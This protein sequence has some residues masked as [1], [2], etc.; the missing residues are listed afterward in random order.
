MSQHEFL[1]NLPGDY[2]NDTYYILTH[3]TN[4]S[5]Q[6]S[7]ANNTTLDIDMSSR[8]LVVCIHGIG[9]FHGHFDY[10]VPVLKQEGYQI[11]VYDLLCRGYS[12]FPKTVVR[13]DG[14]SIFD[15]M[16]HVDQL[17]ELL[18]GLK[19][20][21]QKYH[22]VG[23]SMG[24]ALATLYAAQYPDEIASVT[25]LSPA[26]LMDLG[27]VKFL[28]KCRCLHGIVRSLL[29]NNQETAWRDDFQ[30]QTKPIVEEA[31]NKIRQVYSPKHFEGFWSSVLSFPLFD[32]QET[33]ATLGSSHQIPIFLA[34]AQHDRAVPF[35]PS[36]DRWQQ[37][38]TES[39]HPRVKYVVYEDGAHGFFIEF[40]ELVNKDILKFIKS[41]T[42]SSSSFEEKV[43][44]K[45]RERER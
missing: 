37:I 25:L 41:T 14:T 5:A 34:W 12:N 33:V 10:L 26:G 15:G 31:L 6:N 11:L 38:F 28:R 43:E 23:H 45:E 4:I 18:L 21:T 24:G 7:E 42:D 32:L 30:D 2:L 3:S 19:L 39:N 17:R 27:A 16:G 44:D 1:L 22:L 8:E 29:Q 9:S 13:E 20:T 36:F 40:H 35:H